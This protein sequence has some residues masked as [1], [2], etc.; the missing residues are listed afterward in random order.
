MKKYPLILLILLGLASCDLEQLIMGTPT[1]ESISEQEAAQGLKDAL[2]VGIS[3]GA[4]TL[5]Q[6]DGY[7]GN[8]AIRIPWPEDAIKI[9]NTLRNMG[10]GSEVDKVELALNRAAE[11]AA[12]KAKPIFIDAIR[13]MTI[14]DAM[15]ILFGPED[16]ATQY[17]RNTT[18]DALTRVFR[19]VI[20]N[21]LNKVNATKY[22]DD[23]I[24]LYNQIPLVQ[25]MNPDLAGYVTEKALDGL[26]YTVAQEE[27]KIREDPLA[28]T[29]DLLKKV[30]GYY[31][32]N[33]NKQ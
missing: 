23:A 33:K 19:P 25:K 22:W 29:T 8:P 14:R 13:Q 18:T 12:A 3:R 17:L 5:T 27:K 7:F 11:D 31:D 21:S 30:F 16:A 24:S 1:A 26:F 10:L 6:V 32:R 20:E 4:E 2:S 28:R 9:A 15:N